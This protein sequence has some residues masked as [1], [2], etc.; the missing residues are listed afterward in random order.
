MMIN[1]FTQWY[2]LYNAF[3]LHS[4]ELFFE[5]RE[6]APGTEKPEEESGAEERYCRTRPV[7][8]MDM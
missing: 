7:R 3:L 6:G 4:E 8:I 2:I 5:K 1:Y